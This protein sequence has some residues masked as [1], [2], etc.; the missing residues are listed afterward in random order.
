MPRFEDRAEARVDEIH[1]VRGELVHLAVQ[2]VEDSGEWLCLIEGAGVCLGNSFHER[3]AAE[4]WIRSMFGRIFPEHR[5]DLGCIR[6]PG[7]RFCADEEV[8][9]R[10]AG[11]EPSVTPKRKTPSP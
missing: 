8:L 10:L 6:L 5:C 3:L 9:Q 7:A 2:P 4:T 1:Q 11:P